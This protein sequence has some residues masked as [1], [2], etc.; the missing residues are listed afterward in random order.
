MSATIPRVTDPPAELRPPSV[1][2]AIMLAQVFESAAGS[3]QMLTRNRLSCKIGQRPKSSDH[4][5]QS[6]LP[7]AYAIKYDAELGCQNLY[8][9][10]EEYE[11]AAKGTDLGHLEHA[12][13]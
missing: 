12:A 2:A 7:K 4:G 9:Y 1:R 8:S 13:C 11:G 10:T 5:A 6:S 3:C